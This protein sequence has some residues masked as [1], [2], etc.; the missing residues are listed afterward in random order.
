MKKNIALFAVVAVLFAGIGVYL[1]V[2]QTSPAPAEASAVDALLAESMADAS[3]KT[4][5]LSQWKGRPLV[6]NFWATWCAPCVEEM[7]EL[8][9]LQSELDTG[10]KAQILGIGIDSPANIAQFV[11]KY[12][13]TYPIYVGGMGGS[14]LS[15]K[16]GNQA[17]GL[18]FTVLVSSDGQVKKTYLGRLKMDEL[19]KDLE[20]L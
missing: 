16:L 20:Q 1:G 14:E 9:A 5:A 4:Q 10:K 17:G 15:R 12:Q 2:R 11:S 19:R 6:I 3:G 13:I 7:P 8:S 18:P